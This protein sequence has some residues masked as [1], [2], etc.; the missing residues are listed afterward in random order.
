[1]ISSNEAERMNRLDQVSSLV[2]LFAGILVVLGSLLS[3]RVGTA[4]DPGPGL[5]PFLA[6]ILMAAFSLTIFLK[7]TF[8]KR[9]QEKNV[10]TLW[11]IPHWKKVVYTLA[12]LFVYAI[13]LEKVGFLF[14]T[15]SLFVFLFRKI[16]PQ[17]WK[18]VIGLSVLASAGAYLIFDRILQVQLPRGLFGF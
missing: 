16:E 13:L 5:F 11:A 15:L 9:S 12:V 10:R 17:K 7:A 4:N 2:W 6:G 3:L 18:L 8:Q 14:M 1:M